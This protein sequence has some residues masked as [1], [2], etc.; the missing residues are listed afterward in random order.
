LLPTSRTYKYY[1]E[2]GIS[3]CD[4]WRD[5]FSVFYT[6]LLNNGYHEPEDDSRNTLFTVDRIDVD[7]N[8]EPSNC[9][10]VSM[11][12]QANNKRNNRYET[13]NGETHTIAEWARMRGMPYKSFCNR[14]YRGWSFERI[15]TT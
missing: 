15:M 10:L 9:R 1:G 4:E 5:D 13:Y 11:T 2:R 12:E 14:L 8:Y 6:W 3:I 7:G